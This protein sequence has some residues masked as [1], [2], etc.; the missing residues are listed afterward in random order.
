ML[1]RL[2]FMVLVVFF[3]F[4]A[5]VCYESLYISLIFLIFTVCEGALGLTVLVGISR[6]FGGDYFNTFSLGN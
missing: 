5:F 1:I 2:E 4:I 6:V 3:S